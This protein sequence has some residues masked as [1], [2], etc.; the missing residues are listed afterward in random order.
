MPIAED[1]GLIL[2]LSNWVLQAACRAARAWPEHLQLAVHLSACEFQRGQ[3]VARIRSVLAQSGLAPSR[4]L[5]EVADKAL[6]DDG[7]PVQ[8]IMG[9][10]KALGVQ[11]VLDDFGSG[12]SALQDLRT[13]PL[14]CLKIDSGLVAG[15]GRSPAGRSIVQAIVDLGHAL[16]LKVLAEGVD[17][18]EQFAALRDIRCDEVQGRYLSPPLDGDALLQLCAQAPRA[19]SSMS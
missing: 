7:R 19:G 4:L 16:S 13:Y 8:D 10:L 3:L 15:L 5:L 12:C 9:G 18:P 1:T 6:L 11:L 17:T 14:D 2:P